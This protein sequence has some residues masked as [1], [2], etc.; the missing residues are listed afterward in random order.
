MIVIRVYE[1]GYM[2]CYDLP[3][4]GKTETYWR[5]CE[6]NHGDCAIQICH[7]PMKDK[8]TKKLVNLMIKHLAE[9]MA[10]INGK[11]GKL[12]K[13]YDKIDKN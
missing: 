4:G 12:H 8:Y 11:I 10:D 5:F 13:L 9:K 7:R 1:D 3:R 2:E 6:P